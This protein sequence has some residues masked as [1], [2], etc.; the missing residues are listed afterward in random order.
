MHKVQVA[1]SEGL[2]GF[3]GQ[4]ARACGEVLTAVPLGAA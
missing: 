4:K 1:E 2:P 3:F